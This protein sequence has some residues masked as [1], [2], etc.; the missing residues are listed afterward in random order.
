MTQSCM[1]P[2]EIAE[3]ILPSDIVSGWIGSKN[4]LQTHYSQVNR[5]VYT[6]VINTETGEIIW[7]DVLE[8]NLTV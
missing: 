8:C 7:Y 2:E 6:G 3:R 4:G 1:S 5:Q